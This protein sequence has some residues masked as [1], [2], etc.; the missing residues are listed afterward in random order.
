LK[1]FDVK[2]SLDYFL[3]YIAE[4]VGRKYSIARVNK[5]KKRIW[6]LVKLVEINITEG[7]YFR[8]LCSHDIMKVGTRRKAKIVKGDI[9]PEEMREN[10]ILITLGT[11]IA[12][13]IW[14]LDQLKDSKE[15]Q[16]LL[17]Y[18][19]SYKDEIYHQQLCLD[20]KMTQIVSCTREEGGIKI[21][22]LINDNL[23][24]IKTI[25]ANKGRVFFCGPKQMHIY[26]VQVISKAM[27]IT[28]E[29]LNK[30]KVIVY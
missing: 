1:D 20:S 15:G 5:E 30:S 10:N 8:G 29:Q 9:T 24:Q 17:I 28:P 13:F 11:G 4:N 27:K 12:P 6:L 2:I 23:Q 14:V 25:L 3:K 18:T 16:N 19:N 26:L 21:Q 22:T 7:R